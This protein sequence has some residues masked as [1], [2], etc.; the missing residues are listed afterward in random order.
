MPEKDPANWGAA[1]WV[2]A[3]T[4]AIG[5]GLINWYSRVKSGNTRIFNVVE[6]IGDIFS[7]G[8]IGVGAFMLLDAWDQP[9]GVC[10]VCG[11]IAGHMGTRLLFAIERATKK[12]LAKLGE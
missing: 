2:I 4:F 9:L 10:A 3:L 8:L 5:G 6:L 12:R 1:T 7:S 11:G